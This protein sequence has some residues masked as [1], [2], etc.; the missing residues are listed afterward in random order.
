[1]KFS[2][3]QRGAEAEVWSVAERQM[4]ALLRTLRIKRVG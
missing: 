2:A 4:L 3:R 1:L